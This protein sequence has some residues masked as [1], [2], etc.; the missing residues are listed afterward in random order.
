[1]TVLAMLAL[2]DHGIHS[3]SEL[4]EAL[5]PDQ[6]SMIQTSSKSPLPFLIF[7]PGYIVL[8]LNYWCADQTIVQRVLG[9]KTLKDAQIGPIFAGFIITA[10]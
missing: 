1:M 9:A 10:R 5:K 6:L 3:F 4:K 2:P 7:W 8:G